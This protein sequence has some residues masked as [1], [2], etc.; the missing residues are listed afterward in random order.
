[1][2]SH[3]FTRIENW[4]KSEWFSSCMWLY[5]HMA[6]GDSSTGGPMPCFLGRCGNTLKM[7]ASRWIRRSASIISWTSFPRVPCDVSPI[8]LMRMSRWWPFTPLS[9]SSGILFSFRAIRVPIGLERFALGAKVLVR[10]RVLRMDAGLWMRRNCQT[11][12]LS[13][14]ACCTSVLLAPAKRYMS[15]LLCSAGQLTGTIRLPAPLA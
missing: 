8:S 1:M 9:G 10:A 6:P 3:P 4:H 2:P 14:W 11:G 7:T 5:R 12:L 13:K 15:P